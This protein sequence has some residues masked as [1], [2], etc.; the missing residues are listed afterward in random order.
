MRV[1][2]AGPE[3]SHH[4]LPLVAHG[5]DLGQ[6]SL[7]LRA[8]HCRGEDRIGSAG[9]PPFPRSPTPHPRGPVYPPSVDAASSSRPLLPEEGTE[10]QIQEREIGPRLLVA[11][12]HPVIVGGHPWVAAYPDTDSGEVVGTDSSDGLC[13]SL[14]AGGGW[15]MPE[16]GA[17]GLVAAGSG[18]VVGEASVGTEVLGLVLAWNIQKQAA[19]TI[20]PWL[21]G[22]HIQ[23]QLSPAPG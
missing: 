11:A 23:A 7:I 6:H 1:V 20:R 5:H 8:C 15:D 13:S 4:S 17:D 21:S 10:L 9:S 22:L 18:V 2:V 16:A 3:G 19:G 12:T 14:A